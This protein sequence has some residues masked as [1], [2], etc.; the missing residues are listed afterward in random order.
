MM[1]VYVRNGGLHLWFKEISRF[2]LFE[3]PNQ[4]QA[5]ISYRESITTAL[6]SASHTTSVRQSSTIEH[7]HR[8][9]PASSSPPPSRFATPAGSGPA[10]K[11]FPMAPLFPP[12]HLP[13]SV[14]S[15]EWLSCLFHLK[16]STEDT[17]DE[18][19]SAICLRPGT[20][21]YHVLYLIYGWWFFCF[22][23]LISK[24]K[25]FCEFLLLTL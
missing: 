7:R 5:P 6:I 24:S 15:E 16:S 12:R 1:R 23:A 2:V 8:S 25:K 4:S 18:Q 20:G 3:K 22:K 14:T 21:Y 10:P 19:G 17:Q 13:L 11:P 9:S